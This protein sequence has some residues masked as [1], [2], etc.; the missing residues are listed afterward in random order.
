MPRLR[1]ATVTDSNIYSAIKDGDDLIFHKVN[2]KITDIN[3][4]I[5]KVSWAD[6]VAKAV[7]IDK[8]GVR[9]L[10][11]IGTYGYIALIKKRGKWVEKK[12]YAVL[13]IPIEV[14]LDKY[15]GTNVYWC[16]LSGEARVHF[17]EG[18][19]LKV[20]N[21]MEGVPYDYWRS[22]GVYVDDKH[23]NWLMSGLKYLPF[24]KA[25]WGKVLKR[26]FK[27][28]ENISKVISSGFTSYADR[29]S[30]LVNIPNI[31]EITPQ[32]QAERA[33]HD[34]NYYQ[35]LGSHLLIP[36]F[37]TKEVSYN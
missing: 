31:S 28:S 23:I 30:M 8:D 27:N 16:P 20:C 33:I 17:D 13:Y 34:S 18:I 4:W 10:H 37:N 36:D 21:E 24:Y 26:I 25:W 22:I 3:W 12:R 29:R 19:F 6:H 14:L 2:P 11:A 7:W 15:E 35:L 9:T 5:Q 32:D 1:P